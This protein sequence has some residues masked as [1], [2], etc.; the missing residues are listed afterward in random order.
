MEEAGEL[1]WQDAEPSGAS[2]PTHYSTAA[3]TSQK[4]QKPLVAQLRGKEKG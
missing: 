3:N 2:A 4:R 1:Y